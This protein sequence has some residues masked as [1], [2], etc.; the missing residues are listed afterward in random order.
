VEKGQYKDEICGK[1]NRVFLHAC[2]SSPAKIANRLHILPVRPVQVNPKN[3]FEMFKYPAN[4]EFHSIY[5]KPRG[6]KRHRGQGIL[7]KNGQAFII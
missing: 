3:P 4:S 7:D 6:I 2:N 5:I 1:G